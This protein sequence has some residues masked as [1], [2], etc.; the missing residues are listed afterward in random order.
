MASARIEDLECLITVDTGSNVSIVKPDVLRKLENTVML[1]PVES[2]LKTV[3]GA[4]APIKGKAR[5][6]IAL[7][8]F[9]VTHDF[10]VAGITDDCILGL[11]FMIVISRYRSVRSGSFKCYFEEQERDINA[12]TMLKYSSG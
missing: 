4:T 3:T 7:G 5:L 11:D 8:T 6:H 9:E 10:W 12:R 1:R 2:Y